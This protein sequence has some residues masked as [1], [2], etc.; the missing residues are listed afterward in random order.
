[1]PLSTT[2]EP[3]D[4]ATALGQPAPESGSPI[5]SQWQMWIDDALMLIQARVDSIDPTPSVDQGRLDYVIRE[6]VVAQVRRPDD[7]TQVTVSV[8]D[9]S[10]SRSYRTGAGRVA[11]LD[12][13]WVLLGLSAT[14]GGAFDIDTVSSS[15]LHMDVCS[16]NLGALYCSCGGD[17]AGFPIYEGGGWE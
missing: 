2:V 7:S 9:G 11:I 16:L 8:D 15:I 10:V 3:E 14:G 12:D 6:A 4:I 13:W 5:W 17:I 1:M